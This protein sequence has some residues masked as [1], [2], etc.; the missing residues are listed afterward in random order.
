MYKISNSSQEILEKMLGKRYKDIV[1]MDCD[2]EYI[3]YSKE[4]TTAS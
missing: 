3:L 2:E 4:K 1:N